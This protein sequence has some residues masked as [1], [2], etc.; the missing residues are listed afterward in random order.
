[1]VRLE[2][3]LYVGCAL[4]QAPDDFKK[5][6]EGIKESLRERGH[7]VLEFVG[8]KPASPEEV[9]RW[10]IMQC[11]GK[12]GVMLAIADYPSLGLGWEM[13]TA[14]YLEIPTLAVA[15]IGRSVT[16]LVLGAAEVVPSFEFE[17]YEDLQD[18]PDQFEEF[19][20]RYLLSN[21]GKSFPHTIA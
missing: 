12:C 18:V 10:D 5:S 8:S 4:T 20:S 3:G 16:R 9:Y 21:Y 19:L 7:S 15:Q 13:A 6:V 1:M 14:S 2:N 17:R 11:V